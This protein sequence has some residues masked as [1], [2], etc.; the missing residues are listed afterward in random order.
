MAPRRPPTSPY[1]TGWIWAILTFFLVIGTVAS[2]FVVYGATDLLPAG[3]LAGG[4]LAIVL[5]LGVAVLAFL[6][7]A[8]LLYRIDRLRGVPHRTVRLFE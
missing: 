7:L 5:G 4:A 2:A 3:D 1:R 6:F 8:G